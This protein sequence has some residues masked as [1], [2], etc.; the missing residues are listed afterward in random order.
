M[1]EKMMYQV[2][3]MLVDSIAR[4]E[5]KTPTPDALRRFL[6]DDLPDMKLIEDIEDI[7]RMSEQLDAAG[8]V[9]DP[10]FCMV[11]EADL[12]TDD[13]RLVFE[14]AIFIGASI[15]SG[16]D[17]FIAADLSSAAGDPQILVFDWERSV[18]CRWVRRGTLSGLFQKM[19][20]E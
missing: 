18:P 1:G 10:E 11:R 7:R 12:T 20:F 2:P 6:G 13:P 19:C 14:R 4:G 16:D 3:G 9:D 8:Y 17:V 15:I 5:W